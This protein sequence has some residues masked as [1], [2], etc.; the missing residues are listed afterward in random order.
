[1]TEARE[2]AQVLAKAAGRSLGEITAIVEG[3]A[4]TPLPYAT[5]R[6]ALDASM[7]I[8]PGEQETTASVSVTY[9]L[10]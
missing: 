3:S 4:A 5:E 8:V 1:M 6:A 7:P 10:R 2:R 9:T